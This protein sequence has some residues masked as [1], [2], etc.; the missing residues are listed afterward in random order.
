MST[1]S[2]QDTFD[3]I[4]FDYRLRSVDGMPQGACLTFFCDDEGR[5][6]VLARIAEV[7]GQVD[8]ETRFENQTRFVVHGGQWSLY[9][10]VCFKGAQMRS[11]H[12]SITSWRETVTTLVW[13]CSEQAESIVK[14]E[15]KAANQRFR[16]THPK[17]M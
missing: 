14:D 2:I 3:Y 1:H 6:S 17:W 12:C 15:T 4:R 9:N 7:N 11:V 10:S 16:D 8:S 13:V 5:E